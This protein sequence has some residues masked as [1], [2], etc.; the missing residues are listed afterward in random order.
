[1]LRKT[2]KLKN[3]TSL[4]LTR[5]TTILSHIIGL[6]AA[7]F[8]RLKTQ[9][10][11][12]L[13]IGILIIIVFF[14]L[15]SGHMPFSPTANADAQRMVSLYVDGEK[16]VFATDDTNVHSVL[17]HSGVQL[18]TGDLVEPSLDSTVPQG[19]FNINV[20]RSRP[21]LVQDGQNTYRFLSAYQSPHLLAQAAGLTLY[22]EDQYDMGV[23]TD[24]VGNGAVGVKVTVKRATPL[25][26]RVDGQVKSIRTQATTVGDALKSAGVA[27]GLKDTVSAPLDAPV[28]WNMSVS[29]A[30]VTEVEANITAAIPH[31][32]QTVTDPTMLKGQTQV[33]THGV[34]GQ[35]VALYRIH[36]QDGNETGRELLNVVSQTAPVT[37]VDVVGTKVVFAG[38]VEY[39]RPMVEAAAAQWSLDPNMMLRI[40]SCESHGN[41]T[42]VSQFIINGEHPT[43]LFQYLPSTWRSSGGTNDN[44]FDG[45]A[46]ITI[47][48][49]KMAT[50]GTRAWQCQ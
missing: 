8:Q 11:N 12:S 36:Y 24:V 30:R 31:A 13:A 15:T 48:A 45:A 28:E 34:D 19:F 16:R 26:I 41:A 23:I 42:S 6:L 17:D 21:V 35:R 14:G 40:M 18:Q 10:R 2:K 49:R 46:Q 27:L 37:E 44:I 47:T 1:M 7:T 22:P 25:T 20:Y 5:E 9:P 29:V 32:T 38:S 50:Q 4:V 3:E 33:R 43:G 39:W